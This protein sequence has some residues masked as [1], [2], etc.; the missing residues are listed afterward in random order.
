MS[1][2]KDEGNVEGDLA[3]ASVEKENSSPSPMTM[4][5]GGPQPTNPPDPLLLAR[6]MSSQYL[7]SKVSHHLLPLSKFDIKCDLHAIDALVRKD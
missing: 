6:C 2:S 5:L 4:T 3:R 1:T 7:S